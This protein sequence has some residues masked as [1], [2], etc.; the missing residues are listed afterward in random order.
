MGTLEVSSEAAGYTAEQTAQTYERL[1]SVL[2]D[3]QTA[4][5]T[6]ANLQAIGLSQEDLMLVTDSAIGAW[7]R[8]GDSIPIDGLAESIN[9]TIQA[10]Q[11]TGTFA[12][13]LNWAGTSEDDFNVKL[14]NANG[15]TERANIVLQE[16]TRQGLAEAGQAW[17]DTNDDI[18][19]TNES[20]AKFEE[21]QAKLGEKLTPVKTFLTELAVGGFDILSGSIDRA[22][23]AIQ[24]LGFWWEKTRPKLEKGW[25]KF[26]GTENRVYK[27]LED[28]SYG[29][30]DGSHAG[31]LSYVPWDGY[32]AMLHQG[33]RVLTAAEARAMDTLAGSFAAPASVTAADLRTVTA[34]AVNALS[35]MG[36]NGGGNQ[37]IDVHVYV[38]EK[39]FYRQTLNTLRAVEKEN[40]E[41]LDDV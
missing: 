5:T 39:E 28:G 20:Q 8:Y 2:G 15:T 25:D 38:G 23:K 3:N 24:D 31:G 7:A 21:A 17:I 11:V 37:V 22:T 18:V 9:E 6:V 14:A 30:V 36:S 19:A 1:Y 27:R 40:P 33:E 12:D 29:W 32:V 10:G 4:A 34:S 13:V 35:A 26:F 16:L 41:V